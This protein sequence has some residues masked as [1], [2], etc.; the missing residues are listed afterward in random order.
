M[1]AGRDG[2]TFE[3]ILQISIVVVIQTANRHALAVALQFA[4][5]GTVLPAVVG[6]DCKTTVGP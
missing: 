1:G 2:R 6:L 4:A 5:H 3:E